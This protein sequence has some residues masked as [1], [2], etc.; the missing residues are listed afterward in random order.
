MI[1]LICPCLTTVATAAEH[2]ASFAAALES[3]SV[4]QLKDHVGY[5]ADDKLKGREAGRA[6]G[7]AA[8]QYLADRFEK[9]KLQ[10]AGDGDTFFQN[11]S[12]RYRNVVAL[13]EGSDEQLRREVI[14]I[15]AHYDHVGFGNESNSRGPIG[16]IHN[17]ADDNASGTAAVMELAEAFTMLA[18]PPRR[19]IVFIGFDAEEKGLFGSQHWCKQ[20]TVDRDRLAAMINLDMVGRLR[21]D[22]LCVFGSRTGI[23]LRRLISRQNEDLKLS[24]SW[25]MKAKADHYPFFKRNVPTL[26][27][28]T[29]LHDV[30]HTPK[31]DAH[32]INNAG[33]QRVTRFVFEVAHELAQRDDL[34]GF[35]QQAGAE[36]ETTR[37]RLERP[38]AKPPGRLGVG[39]N[40]D[41]PP[42][43]GLLLAVFSPDSA[44]G[45]GGLQAGDRIIKFAGRQIDQGDQLRSA[46]LAAANPVETIVQRSLDEEPITLDIELTGKPVRLGISW[47][48]DPA[49]PGT[50]ILTRVMAGSPAA[51]AGLQFGDRI[52]RLGGKEFADEAEFL[53]LVAEKDDP[54]EIHVERDGQ[55]FTVTVY[56]EA[57]PPRREV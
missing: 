35:R 21:D 48:V 36:T 25:E 1:L 31:D 32:L 26:M 9:L 24:F 14:V 16:R 10:T 12:G 55:M 2:N 45:K 40:N 44:A 52:Y 33:M 41:A 29:G 8:G 57:K 53:E 30:Y 15:G 43:V 51:K 5:L 17:G 50:I 38:A 49:E 19:S 11:F 47:R 6:G 28:N 56:F 13:L 46:V 34:P 54:L 42:G 27:F 37:K 3:I 4:D 39:W 20:P 7:R 18:E 22:R 23:G